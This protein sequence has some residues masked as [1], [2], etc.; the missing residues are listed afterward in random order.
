MEPRLPWFLNLE[1]TAGTLLAIPDLIP[2][3]NSYNLL[4]ILKKEYHYKFSFGSAPQDYTAKLEPGQLR[5]LWGVAVA[6]NGNFI[7]ADHDGDAF[8]IFDREGQFLQTLSYYD[9]TAEIKTRIGHP[10]GITF[11]L[12]QE[13]LYVVEFTTHRV[14]CWDKDFNYK[15]HFS[16]T[17]EGQTLCRPYDITIDHQGNILVADS[18]NNCVQFFTPDW[19][20]FKSLG[21]KGPDQDC[22]SSPT[23]VRVDHK[24]NIIVLDQDLKCLKKF[25]SEG[26][27]IRTLGKEPLEKTGSV[28]S[29]DVD[30]VGNIILA[31]YTADKIIVLNPDGE[32]IMEF[33]EEGKKPG[34][35]GAPQAL[36]IDLQGRLIIGEYRNHRVSVWDEF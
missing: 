34:M 17:K 20:W 11:D 21:K 23:G 13:N 4:G 33:G 32:V 35:F 5:G 24:G 1:S 14:S 25:D 27:F 18:G 6:K 10:I 2:L 15:G 28:F 3:I 8:S 26:N 7:V 22:F 36:T 29:F 30:G 19:K 31:M 12:T 16:Q 9:T